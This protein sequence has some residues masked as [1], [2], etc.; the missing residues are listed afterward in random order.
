MLTAAPDRLRGSVPKHHDWVYAPKG[1][2]GCS[3]PPSRDGSFGASTVVA[4]KGSEWPQWVEPTRSGVSPGR[5]GIGAQTRHPTRSGGTA[6]IVAMDE[7]L[8]NARAISGNNVS[9]SPQSSHWPSRGRRSVPVTTMSMSWLPHPEHTSR[10]FQSGTV[11][12]APYR[13]ACPAGSGS[14]W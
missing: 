12:V 11:V 2:P 14:T 10:F 8:A 13:W 9:G 3:D 7:Q 6:A 4:V 5:A 1:S